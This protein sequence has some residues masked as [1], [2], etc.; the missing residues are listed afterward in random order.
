MRRRRH[1]TP[2]ELDWARQA[3]GGGD[4]VSLTA[5]DLSVRRDSAAGDGL[6]RQALE[7]MAPYLREEGFVFRGVRG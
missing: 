3:A 4:I 7:L 2:L 5:G 1:L 6:H